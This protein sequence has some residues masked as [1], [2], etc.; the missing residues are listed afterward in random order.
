M[1]RLKRQK[2]ATDSFLSDSA[3]STRQITAVVVA[4]LLVV[5]LYPVGARAMAFMNVII[6]DATNTANQAHVDDHGDLQVAG[7]VGLT[8]TPTVGLDPSANVVRNA[9]EP[10][11][12]V[13][14]K[15]V[16]P[17]LVDNASIGSD[18]FS[19]PS[20]RRLAIQFV[21]AEV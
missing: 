20:G 14:Q 11:R 9:D 5:L 19:V 15:T 18:S 1:N 16:H 13:F 6:T 3:F 12:L 21:S 17:T 2:R 4:T 8:G 10:A 7:K